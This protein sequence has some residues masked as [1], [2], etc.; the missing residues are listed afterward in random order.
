MSAKIC[1]QFEIRN[2]LIMKDT[3]RRLGFDFNEVSEDQIEMKRSYHNIVINSKTGSI[4]HD[5]DNTHDVNKIKQA[6]SVNYYRA[7]AIKEGMQL[8]EE[9][10]A[11]GEVILYM[12]R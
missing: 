10:N 8:R 6:Y 1:V 3:L 4:T 7:E 9:T 12:T 5:S 2:M 11:H